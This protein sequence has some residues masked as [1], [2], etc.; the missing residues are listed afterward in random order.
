MGAPGVLARKQ[1]PALPHPHTSSSWHLPTLWDFLRG[2]QWM[3]FWL[4]LPLA[5]LPCLS[6][7][8]CAPCLGHA[9]C[10]RNTCGPEE[11][12]PLRSWE[13]LVG[14]PTA[15][16]GCTGRCHMTKVCLAFAPTGL[17]WDAPP[18]RALWWQ[19]ATGRVISRPLAVGVWPWGVPLTG[20]VAVVTPHQ[21]PHPRPGQPT[22]AP[23]F[24]SE[25]TL[26]G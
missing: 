9:G 22:P 19:A 4:S 24:F 3:D 8:P 18:P 5:C 11:Q 21:P 16:R 10:T 14:T 6:S 12:T 17:E 23:L 13:S 26:P 1:P 15:H 7:H 25:H 2:H 20:G